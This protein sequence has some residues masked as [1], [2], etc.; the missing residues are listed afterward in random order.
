MLLL[1]N[2]TPVFAGDVGPIEPVEPSRR[3]TSIPVGFVTAPD[4]HQIPMYLLPEDPDLTR[5]ALKSGFITEQQ[6]AG[7]RMLIRDI[8][9]TINEAPGEGHPWCPFGGTAATLISKGWDHDN[10][11]FKDYEH[12]VGWNDDFICMTPFYFAWSGGR[13]P[14]HE[15]HNDYQPGIARHRL[16]IG[17]TGT[18]GWFAAAQVYMRWGH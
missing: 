10:D 11:Y 1:L 8:V 9:A 12:P 16:K 15:Y 14:A 5:A 18:P 17:L 2:V 13:G 3:G 7:S 6:V 4:G